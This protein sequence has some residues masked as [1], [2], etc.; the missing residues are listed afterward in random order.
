MMAHSTVKKHFDNNSEFDQSIYG[1]ELIKM[2]SDISENNVESIN[3]NLNRRLMKAISEKED[4]F[5]IGESDVVMYSKQMWDSEKSVWVPFDI[6]G[7]NFIVNHRKEYLVLRIF[8]P[9]NI[10]PEYGNSINGWFSLDSSYLNKTLEEYP[11]W[12][13]IIRHDRQEAEYEGDYEHTRNIRKA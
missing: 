13:E 6:W 9:C 2:W 11:D 12:N 1:K 4:Q 10:Q 8:R 3:S 7:A 5:K